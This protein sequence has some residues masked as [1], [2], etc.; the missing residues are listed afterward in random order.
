MVYKGPLLGGSGPE[1]THG[2]FRIDLAMERRVAG[3]SVGYIVELAAHK[4]RISAG[5]ARLRR[6]VPP[7]PS[8]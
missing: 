1:R 2:Q 7:A 5:C 8:R 4:P 6:R 3:V